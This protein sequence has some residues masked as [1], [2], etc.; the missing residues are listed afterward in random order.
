MLT[1]LRPAKLPSVSA[2]S[3]LLA[4][5]LAS[6]LSLDNLSVVVVRHRSPVLA[7]ST[8]VVQRAQLGKLMRTLLKCLAM[9]W[10][11]VLKAMMLLV[12]LA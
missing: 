7:Y 2:I 4:I 3:P 6:P 8:E 5:K 11:T 9:F 12:V 1:I 10:L